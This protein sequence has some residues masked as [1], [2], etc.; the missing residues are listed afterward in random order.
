M[1]FS[2][3][4]DLSWSE[5]APS[6]SAPSLSFSPDADL[7]WCT[8]PL[9]AQNLPVPYAELPAS[10]VFSE[11]YV[12]S[13]NERRQKIRRDRNSKAARKSRERKQQAMEQLKKENKALRAQLEQA[14]G[15]LTAANIQSSNTS[16]QSPSQSAVITTLDVASNSVDDSPNAVDGCQL[17][18]DEEDLR[19]LEPGSPLTDKVIN[20]VLRLL[21][22]LAPLT[23]ITIDSSADETTLPDWL[24]PVDQYNK[25]TIL[26]PI[27]VLSSGHW[28]LA[29]RDSNGARL[30]DSLPTVDHK[31]SAEERINTLFC[32]EPTCWPSSETMEIKYTNQ[33]TDSVDSGVAVL[34]NAIYIVAAAFGSEQPLPQTLDAELWRQVL[35]ILLKVA[36]GQTY[37]LG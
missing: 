16:L 12:D 28:L 4:P 20:A 14:R 17:S 35:L 37:H 1:D 9:S 5:S 19:C 13:E 25:Q 29:V 2:Y 30:L 31:Q 3:E 8:D 33:E 34:V 18:L 11:Q 36:M 27:H 22:S 21:G 15:A 7:F 26:V 6:L 10:N 23:I 32:R 24:Q